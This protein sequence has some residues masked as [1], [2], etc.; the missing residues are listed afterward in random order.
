MCVILCVKVRVILSLNAEKHSLVHCC[1][2]A[3][4]CRRNPSMSG[5]RCSSVCGTLCQAACLRSKTPQLSSERYVCVRVCMCE[6][7]VMPIRSHQIICCLQDLAV[8]PL[9]HLGQPTH[10][11]SFLQSYM[12][13]AHVFVQVGMLYDHS[14]IWANTQFEAQPWNMVWNLRNPALWKPFF[15]TQ[16]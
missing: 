2:F 11:R 12:F 4:T 13:N 9:Q 14:N 3:F 16:V 10:K 5:R 1:L 6:C 7:T 8:R 15:G